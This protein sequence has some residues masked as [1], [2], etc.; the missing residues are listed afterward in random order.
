MHEGLAATNIGGC[1]GDRKTCCWSP[2]ALLVL[3]NDH[4]ALA[5]STALVVKRDVVELSPCSVYLS[6]QIGDVAAER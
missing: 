1:A 3:G 5:L 2:E 6:L 4:A